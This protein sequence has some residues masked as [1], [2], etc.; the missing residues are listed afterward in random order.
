MRTIDTLPP[1]ASAPSPLEALPNDSFATICS[2]LT[3]SDEVGLRTVSS[4]LRSTVDEL[5]IAPGQSAST[6][7]NL[8][9]QFSLER[10]VDHFK[11]AGW[12]ADGMKTLP[13]RLSVAFKKACESNLR[14]AQDQLVAYVGINGERLNLSEALNTAIDEGR[15]DMARAIVN[16]PRFGT[17]DN[18][19]GHRQLVRALS[20]AASLGRLEIVMALVGRGV[21]PNG[22]PRSNDSFRYPALVG[23]ASNGRLEVVDYLL[24]NSD[25]DPMINGNAPLYFAV[26]NGNRSVVE[27]MLLD[28]RIDPNRMDI[29]C[30]KQGVMDGNEQSMTPLLQS[31]R[32][33]IE[34]KSHIIFCAALLEKADYVKGALRRVDNPVQLLR[35]AKHHADMH[36]RTHRHTWPEPGRLLGQILHEYCMERLSDG[37]K[38]SV[39]RWMKRL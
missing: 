22:I 7:S 25:A 8:T 1:A 9:A 16:N 38:S 31:A 39:Q 3:I 28:S 15:Y 27:R 17:S 23:A 12:L 36:N 24:N 6:L 18:R 21:D 30:V 5:R 37:A 10:C 26:K 2:F 35:C 33:G 20:L 29:A 14:C 32:V 13:T 34:L 11:P 4:R 19:H